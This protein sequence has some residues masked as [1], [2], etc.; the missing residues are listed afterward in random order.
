MGLRGTRYRGIVFDFNGV[1]FWDADLQVRSWQVIAKNLRGHEMTDDELATHMHG[2]PNSYVLGYLA[3]RAITGQELLDMT[4][5]KEAF[6]RE[7]CLSKPRRLVLSPGAQSL[8]ET[9][10]RSNIRSEE[11][12][13]GKECRSRWS[14]YH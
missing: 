7:L 6:Y 3:G 1:L 10:A 9:L 8:L 2:R 4:Q 14:P 5:V 11:R 12:R 13:V